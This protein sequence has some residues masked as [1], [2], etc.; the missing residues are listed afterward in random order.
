M[1]RRVT[2]FLLFPAKFF[3]SYTYYLNLSVCKT[4]LIFHG[5]QN[6]NRNHLHLKYHETIIYN[7]VLP[8]L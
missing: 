6:I 2:K 8:S 4:L 7:E 1:Y 3:N 5:P